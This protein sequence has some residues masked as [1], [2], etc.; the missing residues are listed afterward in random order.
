VCREILDLLAN[1][2]AV[3]KELWLTNRMVWSQ[4]F[5]EGIA[6]VYAKRRTAIPTKPDFSGRKRTQ[7]SVTDTEN[8]QSKGKETAPST[9]ALPLETKPTGRKKAAGKATDE[10]SADFEAWWTVYPR[11]DEKRVAYG[12]YQQRIKEGVTADILLAAAKNYATY[13]KTNG[14]EK[15]FIK[16]AS[17][18]LSKKRRFEDWVNMAQHAPQ[19]GHA[20]SDQPQPFYPNEFEQDYYSCHSEPMKGH[21]PHE[22]EYPGCPG[23][24]AERSGKIPARLQK[25]ADDPRYVAVRKS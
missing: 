11:K 2:D 4:N 5:I 14:K 20:E 13:C 7:K 1:I 21:Y 15:E 3:D 24:K 17:T 10:Y 25:W 23:C 19:Q 18:F 8:T 12:H 9:G 6:D 22:P 16:M